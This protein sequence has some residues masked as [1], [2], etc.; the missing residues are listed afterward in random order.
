M[1]KLNRSRH[2]LPL[3]ENPL[4]APPSPAEPQSTRRGFL[5]KLVFSQSPAVERPGAATLVCI[6]LRG[7]A[8]TLNMLVPFGDDDYY[9]NRPTLSIAA[10][11]KGKDSAIRLDDFYGLHPKMAPLESV[12]KEGRLGIA[13]AVGS[14]NPTGSH[15]DAQDQIEHG[16]SYGNNLGGGWLGRHLRSRSAGNDSPLAGIAIGAT[17]PESLRGAPGA[18]AL[19]SLDEMQLPVS[20]GNPQAISRALSQMYE[21]EVGIIGRQGKET[22]DLLRRVERLR[23]KPYTP[24]EGA[25][26][27]SDEFGAGL[28]EIA[29]IV[30]ANLGLEVACIDLG[31]WDTHF[32]QGTSNGLQAG[33][34]DSLSRGLAAFDADLQG[35]RDRVTTI[36]MTEFGRRLYENGSAGTDH[37]RGFAFFAM[38]E[39]INGGKIHG[40]WPGL[41]EEPSLPGPGG[42]EVKIDYRSV[43][44]EILSAGIGARKI[45]QVFPGFQPQPI[46]IIRAI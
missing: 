42:M 38:G 32:F 2:F 34:I 24:A 12:F 20:S 29:R 27:P 35:Y 15:F 6:F 39:K 8:D 46:G 1:L 45:D 33:N 4:P 10:P 44:G 21:A 28:R 5:T 37:G 30:K 19:R 31:G 16:E 40:T 36:A 26:Y 13:Q 17:L 41:K 11:G 9:R 23:G 3:A 14:D 18:S 25:L 43:L 22:L 7:G